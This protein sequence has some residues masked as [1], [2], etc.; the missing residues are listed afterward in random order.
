MVETVLRVDIAALPPVPN[1]PLPYRQQVTAIRTYFTGTEALRDAGGPVTRC[2]LAPKWI[3]PPIVVVT[4]PKGAHDVLGRT[5]G[6]VDKALPIYD[7]VRRILGGNV[8]DFTHD[9]WLP[10][11]RALQPVF[12][13]QHVARFAGHMAEAAEGLP[14]RWPDGAE[15][16]L[17]SECHALTLRALGRS[18]LG[19]DLDKRAEA[20]GPALRTALKYCADR[21]YRPMRAPHWLPTPARRRALAASAALHRLAAEILHA[22]R[23]DPTVDAPLVHALIA[24]TDPETGQPLS[25]AQICHEL[26]LFMLA[27]HDTTATT[28]VEAV[29]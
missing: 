25:D 24:A 18:V 12:T 13:K 5:D 19:L 29:F 17:D 14:M 26:V 22:C 11:R 4:S 28:L 21:A 20:V 7:E 9:A 1:N 6:F 23:A 3:T 27:G 16:D 2:K 8:F 10:R 15:V